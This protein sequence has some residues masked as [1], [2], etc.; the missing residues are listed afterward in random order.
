MVSRVATTRPRVYQGA[1]RSVRAF[2]CARVLAGASE[3]R[4]IQRPRCLVRDRDRDAQPRPFVVG[5]GGGA[6]AMPTNLFQ[7]D[8][9]CRIRGPFQHV[10]LATLPAPT[11][12]SRILVS[13]FTSQT[14]TVN[15]A[16][17]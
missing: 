5:R 17:R 10:R 3:T 11:A 12:Y 7:L 4:A 16:N 14:S 9:A 13:R 15:P 8:S 2:I 1:V 6:H